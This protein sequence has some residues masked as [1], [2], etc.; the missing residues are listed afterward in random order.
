VLEIGQSLAL[1][2]YLMIRPHPH[3]VEMK[4]NILRVNVSFHNDY[5]TVDAIPSSCG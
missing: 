1:S 4:I 2:L 5:Y 3:L